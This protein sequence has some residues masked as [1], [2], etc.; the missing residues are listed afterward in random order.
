[1]PVVALRT[2]HSILALVQ[3]VR[4]TVHH[5]YRLRDD[6]VEHMEIRE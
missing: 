6:Q 5:I 4:V 1:M 3:A 2:T